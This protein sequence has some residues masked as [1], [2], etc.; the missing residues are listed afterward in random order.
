VTA[1]RM[2][3]GCL[4]AILALHVAWHGWLLPP[5]RVPVWLPIGLAVLPAVPALLSWLRSGRLAPVWSGIASLFYFCHGVMEA[6]STPDA[7]V[8]ASVEILLSLSCI[9]ASGWPGLVAR[10]RRKATEG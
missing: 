9:V 4:L 8:L 10:R 3:L 6:W 7:R 2:A 1:R 5:D